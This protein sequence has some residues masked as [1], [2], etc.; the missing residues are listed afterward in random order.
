MFEITI[1]HEFCAG[2]AIVIKGQRESVHGHNFR[3]TAVVCGEQLDADGLLCDFHSVER[4]L[5]RITGQYNNKSLNET[6]PFDKINPTAENIARQIAEELDA[7]L[8]SV[9]R[10]NNARVSAVRVTESPG[11]AAVYRPAN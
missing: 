8:A 1:D 5:R 4:Q 9:L 2:H 11:C 10:A 7:S 6:E 3:V